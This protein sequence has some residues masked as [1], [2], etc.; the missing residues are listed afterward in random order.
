MNKT[1]VAFYLLIIASLLIV[2]YSVGV[3]HKMSTTMHSCY[4]KLYCGHGVELWKQQDGTWNLMVYDGTKIHVRD[5][6]LHGDCI[7]ANPITDAD[8]AFCY[9]D[10]NSADP[11]ED[12]V[13][14][15]Y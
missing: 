6:V 12:E 15:V 5:N 7:C 8:I 13:Q 2:S 9:G 4:A 14:Y 1:L 11:L 3:S 10:V